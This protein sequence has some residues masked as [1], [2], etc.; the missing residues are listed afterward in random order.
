MAETKHKDRDHALLGPSSAKRWMTCTPSARMEAMLP[1][2]SSEAAD[3]GT[4]AHE[5]A[6]GK[7]RRKFTPDLYSSRKLTGLRQRCQ[8][9]PLW[10]DEME[11]T[12]DDYVEKI[13][14]DALGFSVMPLVIIEEKLE[15]GD[16]IPEGFGTCDCALIGDNRICVYDYKHGK[17]VRVD[18]EHNYQEYIYA[19][20]MLKKYG[21]M[22]NIEKVQ[23]GIIQPRIP[24]GITTYEC[25]LQEV[26]DFGEL[27]KTTAQTAYRGDGDPVLGEHCQFCNAKSI[28][29]AQAMQCEEI[30]SKVGAMPPYLTLEE[31]GRYLY[32]GKAVS[33]WYAS[34]SKYAL[35]AVQGGATVPGWKLVSGSSVR[36]FDDVE[37]AFDILAENDVKRSSLYET[38]PLSVAKVEGL[39]GKK[40]VEELI[41]DHIVVVQGAPTLAPESSK[42][43]AINVTSAEEAF[44]A[45]Q[46]KEE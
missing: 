37:K 12:T 32:I 42:K 14:S 7:L 21:W 25:D 3:E 8:K 46:Q 31:V 11:K 24:D 6:E 20:G 18:A 13:Y 45:P 40:V 9:N 34:L 16:W 29:R 39:V 36:K 2:E 19:L 35:E 22:A 5:L 28:C 23:L 26:L 30:M 41:G 38:K 44:G 33:D 15:L 10:N 17:G 4:L 1:N 27:V 43:K